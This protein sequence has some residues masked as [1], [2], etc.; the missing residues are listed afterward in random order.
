MA[1]SGAGMKAYEVQK[2]GLEALRAIE[3]PQPKAARGEVLVR[4]R[5]TSLNYRDIAVIQGNYP[6]PPG[7]GPHIP[8]SD[9]AGE[10]VDVGEGV[11][12]FRKGDRVAA[13]F[14]QTW[15]SGTPGPMAAL[16]GP[17]VDGM[18]AE[19]VVLDQEGLVAIPD[20][21]SFEDAA[22]LPCAAVTAWHA[23]FVAGKPIGP[24]DTVLV[25]GTGGV[26]I[27]A[28]QF[29]RAAGAGV[30]ATSS[31]DEKLARAA[32]LGASGLIN[33]KTS[34][35]WDKEVM[36]ITGGK[37]VDCVVEVGGA[38][39]LAR[40]YRSLGF[41]GK[42]CLIGILAGFEGDTNPHPLAF[43]SGNL[44]GIFVGSR[45]M[46]EDMLRAMTINAIKP[47]IDSTFGFDRAADA[48]RHMMAGKHFGKVV[49]KV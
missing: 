17:G 44:H 29:A 20:G 49:T 3:R 39:T 30:I 4:V 31:S 35:D 48:Y 26:S 1:E 16:G 19:Y 10:V 22:C 37:G 15:V 41:G 23:L 28:L 32:K 45:T 9:G 38:G 46:F 2:G 11:T 8:L 13:T 21:L 5:A 25:L 12:R 6:G 43:K 36:R 33:Y 18:L 42:V 47:E 27:F 24:G 14:F 7:A 40:S 34:P